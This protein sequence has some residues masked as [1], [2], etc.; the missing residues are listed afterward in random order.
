MPQNESAG[1]AGTWHGAVA[2]SRLEGLVD[3]A[4]PPA[5]QESVA[6][7]QYQRAVIAE[8]ER[9]IAAGRRRVLL[10]APTGAG[11]TVIAADL[12]RRAIERGHGVLIL[13]HRLELIE[14]AHAKLFDLG[15]DAGTIKAGFP[16]RL[17]EPVQIASVQT[18]TARAIR[19]RAIDLPRAE[20][21]IV[22]EAHH[23]RAKTWRAVIAAYPR[24]VILGLTATPCRGDGKGL[25]NI[26]DALIECPPVQELINLGCL[27]PTRVYAPT[28]PDLS[29]VTVR[30]GDYAAAALEARMDQAP[31][32]GDIV[33]HWHR[34]A[35]RR[36][37]VVFASGVGHSV[38]LRDE[39]RRSGVAA[40]H[41]DGA[42]PIEER[43]AILKRLSRGEVEIVSNCMVL[44]EG[45][46]SPDVSC[47]VL[48]RPTRQM[49][50]YRQMVGRVLR[51]APGKTDAI[52]LDHAGAVFAHGFV[53]EPVSWTL[54]VDRRAENPTHAARGSYHAP[55]L[56]TCP[57]CSA[58][59]FEG[60]A[61]PV[62]GWLPKPK[63][64]SIDVADGE[65]GP[66]DHKRRTQ[67]SEWTPAERALFHAMLLHIA[68]DRGYRSGWAGHKYRERFG[69]WPDAPPWQLPAPQ[70][71]DDATLAWVRS[72]QI[73]YARAMQKRPAA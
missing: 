48:A 62:C 14:Q 68:Q 26:F 5:A 28:R 23:A 71:P 40:E 69:S 20:L 46:D 73:A 47:I 16:M 12:V 4:P 39:F 51:P 15:I 13:A 43:D 21:V 31:L 32:I 56:T 11:K 72:R 35:E 2:Q 55:S 58:V 9:A 37:T 63:P 41:I 36:R 50:L 19:G 49:G 29:G 67:P 53:E 60:R 10:V 45:W 8:L 24:A 64:T 22:D 38:H 6:L 34:H 54:D 65:L 44:T 42:T 3:N 27:V 17:G 30:Q 57:E 1:Q 66:V 33:T 25:G 59:R 52:V 18:L 7:R 61:C 70:P